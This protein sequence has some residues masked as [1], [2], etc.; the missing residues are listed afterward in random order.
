MKDILIKVIKGLGLAV[1][2]GG[3]AYLFFQKPFPAFLVGVVMFLSMFVKP[4]QQ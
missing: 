3:I 2:F 4:K 1:V